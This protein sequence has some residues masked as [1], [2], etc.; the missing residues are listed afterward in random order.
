LFMR[1]L[2]LRTGEALVFVP[3]AIVGGRGEDIH[4]VAATASGI[5]L[6]MN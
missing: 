4:G 6:A 1:I 2:A 3:S 5:A